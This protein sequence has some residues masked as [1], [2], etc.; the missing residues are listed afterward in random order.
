MLGE[1][2]NA[3][4]ERKQLMAKLERAS[5]RAGEALKAVEDQFALVQTENSGLKAELNTTKQNLSLRE[6]EADISESTGKQFKC[7]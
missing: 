5:M 3:E 7:G 1:R 2:A 4:E 6:R